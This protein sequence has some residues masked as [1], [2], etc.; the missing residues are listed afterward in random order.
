[1]EMSV[2]LTEYIS[3]ARFI[4]LMRPAMAQKGAGQHQRR[5]CWAERA[6]LWC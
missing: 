1:M 3:F 5:W 6:P 2:L 4:L